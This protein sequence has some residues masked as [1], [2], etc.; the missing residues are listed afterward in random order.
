[1]RAPDRN[2]RWPD[3]DKTSYYLITKTA[4]G[5]KTTLKTRWFRDEFYNTMEDYNS[6][7]PAGKLSTPKSTSSYDDYSLGGNIE[8]DFK[9]TEAQLLK[10]AVSQKKDFHK[11]IEST[12]PGL[13][14]KAE[15]TT[16]S[17]G[18]EYSLQASEKLT[19]IVGASYDQNKVNKAEYVTSSK[20]IGSYNTY[21]SD[22]F[23]PETALYY[24]LSDLTTIYGSIAKKSNM[25]TLSERYST[26][27]GTFVP[28]PSLKAEHSINYEI[29]AEHKL[30]DLHLAKVA[31]FLSSSNDYIASVSTPPSSCSAGSKC[32]Q[33]QNIG[34]EEHKGLEVSLDSLWGNSLQSSFSYTYLDAKIK[35]NALSPYVTDIPKHSVVGRLKYSPIAIVDIIPQFRYESDRYVS[36]E[37]QYAGF[38]TSDFFLMDVKVAYRPMKAIE[39]AVGVKN[40]FDKNYF[41][42][43]GYPQEGRSYY[44]NARYSF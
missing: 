9:I 13:D 2:W 5:D 27:F 40:L 29:G 41:Y 43:Y 31:L 21:D 6:T 37:A 28:N 19:W 34:K 10:L 22:A 7:K 36:N 18:L 35:N 1:M 24:K 30:N 11:S 8:L 16:T 25:P 33:S 4:I 17:Y 44:A 42:S 12:S 14:T 20:T 39:L 26:K 15:G 3:W 23:N 32:S 38:K